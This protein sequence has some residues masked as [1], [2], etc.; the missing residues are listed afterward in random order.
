M[1]SEILRLSLHFEDTPLTIMRR[2][3]ARQATGAVSPVAK[4]GKLIL[5]ADITSVSVKAYDSAGDLIVATTPAK[6]DVWFDTLQTSDVWTVIVRGG[7]FLY[8]CPATMF[9]SGNELV[10]LEVTV[11][12]TSGEPVRAVW[13]V[14]VIDLNQS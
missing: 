7:N 13:Q 10:T 11:T 1:M 4:E 2:F 9:P 3:C 6:A 12:L 14:P 5:L 8:D